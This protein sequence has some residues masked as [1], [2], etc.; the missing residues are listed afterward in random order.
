M[1]MNG[2]VTNKEREGSSVFLQGSGRIEKN[3]E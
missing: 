2:G 1:D 3:E